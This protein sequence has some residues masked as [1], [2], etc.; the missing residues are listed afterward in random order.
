MG[1]IVYS[2]SISLDGYIETK[3]KKLDWCIID[4]E[5][6]TAANE[7]TRQTDV[8][9]YGRRLYQLMASYWPTA[10]QDPSAAPVIAEF[11]RIWREKP[12]VIFS[13]TLDKVDWNSRLVKDNIAQE[14]V[15]LKAQYEGDLA[16]GGAELAA[17]FAKLDLIDEYRLTIHPVILG[18]GTPFFANHEKPKNLQLIET[19][20]YKS[21]VVYLSYRRVRP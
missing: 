5:F 1:K 6:H 21:G 12:K 16:V 13:R 11:A 9:L 19:R 2:M 10:D 18:G 14:A 20:P 3:D 17:A 7:E 4:E 8:L 15:A